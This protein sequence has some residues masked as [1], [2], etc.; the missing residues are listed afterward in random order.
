MVAGRRS[1]P[2]PRTGEGRRALNDVAI[3]GP[4]LR[5][6]GWVLAAIVFGMMVITF[7]DVAGRDF[8]NSPLPA[9]FELTRLA[10]GTM[11]FVALPLVTAGDE[12]VTIGLL[13]GLFRG[14]AERL[15][16]F[17]VTLFVA[18]LCAV[19]A[20]ELWIQ[21]GTLLANNERM[22]FL[23]VRLAPYVYAMSVLTGFTVVV[24]L[25]QA[26]MKLRGTF[27]PPEIGGI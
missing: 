4:I 16:R 5:V 26:V 14:R 6:L 8:F 3:L 24:A 18:V 13:N 25:L 12:N 19:W 7:V 20:R 21:A 15:K 1:F 10:L 9:A 17:V 22:M 23:G 11:V 2:R 27:K